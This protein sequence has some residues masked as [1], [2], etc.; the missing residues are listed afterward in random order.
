MLR[1]AVVWLDGWYAL[2][3]TDG[4]GVVLWTIDSYE[5]PAVSEPPAAGMI[6]GMNETT[7]DATP[8]GVLQVSNQIPLGYR[9]KGVIC[10]VNIAFGTSSGLSSIMIGDSTMA[11]SWGTIGITAGLQTGQV[12]FHRGDQPIAAT[13][14]TIL[15]SAVGGNYDNVGQMAVRA[16][17]NL[18]RGGVNCGNSHL[19]PSMAA[20]TQS[21]FGDLLRPIIMATSLSTPGMV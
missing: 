20:E 17:G 19:Q 1:K 2:T 3:L 14:Y 13:A 7:V 12:D 18:L 15:L 8:G 4:H 6:S 9:V 16:F 21:M 11:D 10:K 5:Y